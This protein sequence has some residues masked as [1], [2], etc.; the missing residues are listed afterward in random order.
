MN[1][2]YMSMSLAL[3][4]VII[5][6]LSITST[7]MSCCQLLRNANLTTQLSNYDRQ[8][9]NSTHTSYWKLLET[10]IP[11]A[12]ILCIG[13]SLLT[14]QCKQVQ[15]QCESNYNMHFISCD[16]QQCKYSE[17]LECQ[18]LPIL[19]LICHAFVISSTYDTLQEWRQKPS[20]LAGV[21]SYVAVLGFAGVIMFDSQGIKTMERNW[22]F[23]CVCAV[24]LAV[25]LLHACC[26][27]ELSKVITSSKSTVLQ[28][29][30]QNV[31]CDM[32]VRT[33]RNYTL[34]ESV[35]LFA[36]ACFALA[37]VCKIPMAIQFE[38]SVLFCVLAL[39]IINAIS[40]HVTYEHLFCT[41]DG[42][43]IK[44][45][46]QYEFSYNDET[47]MQEEVQYKPIKHYILYFWIL[48]LFFS[49]PVFIVKNRSSAID[50]LHHNKENHYD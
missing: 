39:A 26:V 3:N 24:T 10:T 6:V 29:P 1:A 25:W 5:L 50:Y 21:L 33:R 9:L 30:L 15:I 46:I 41:D 48:C 38:Y 36:L 4:F 47:R 19:A 17:K 40:H 37:F 31:A 14:Q 2:S 35:Y 49:F 7:Y 32:T 44:Q 34:V 8:C 28:S 11:C 23:L 18:L 12:A 13:L 43:R 20:I 22:H 45:N 16:L 42:V 27:L